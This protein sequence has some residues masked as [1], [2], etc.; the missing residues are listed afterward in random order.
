MT[1]KLAIKGGGGGLKV[2]PTCLLL[3]RSEF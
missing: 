3:W 1:E 2:Q